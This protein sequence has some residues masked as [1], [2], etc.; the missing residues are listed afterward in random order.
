MTS[1]TPTQ[2]PGFFR[3]SNTHGAVGG[4]SNMTQAQPAYA[5]ASRCR[6]RFAWPFWT[7][8]STASMCRASARSPAR[9]SMTTTW[10]T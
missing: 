6:P 5:G 3:H 9:R 10:R 2:K 4:Q 8:C 7:W 1:Q